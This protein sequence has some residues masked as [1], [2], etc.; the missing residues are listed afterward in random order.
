MITKSTYND[1]QVLDVINT[2]AFDDGGYKDVMHQNLVDDWYYEKNQDYPNL[3][4]AK[5][6]GKRILQCVI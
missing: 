6:Y 5:F 4:L 2:F 1:Q 3:M